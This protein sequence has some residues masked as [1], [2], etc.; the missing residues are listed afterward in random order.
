[1][2]MRI[3]SL[4][5]SLGL[6]VAW[7]APL[8]HAQAYTFSP[9]TYSESSE[10]QVESQS[11]NDVLST[12]GSTSASLSEPLGMGTAMA[13][14]TPGGTLDAPNLASCSA[15]GNSN[16]TAQRNNICQLSAEVMEV[17]YF[18]ITGGSNGVPVDI[19]ATVEASIASGG[20]SVAG[21]DLIEAEAFYQVTQTGGTGYVVTDPTAFASF[22]ASGDS[23]TMEL[24]QEFILYPGDIYETRMSVEAYVNNTVTTVG[25][26]AYVNGN[27]SA[28]VDPEI[29]IDPTFLASNPGYSIDFSPGYLPEPSP[30]C[31]LPLGA[32]GLL[33]RRRKVLVV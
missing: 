30:A 16:P 3:L 19:V 10:C 24:N 15:I 27:A 4:I 14:G 5:A 31:L 22:S 26:P 23:Q 32:M 7:L 6:A 25:N 1:M 2:K 28:S 20:T 29:Y 11:N 12:A 13:E 33:G 17:G 8:A 21:Q 18:G 9:S